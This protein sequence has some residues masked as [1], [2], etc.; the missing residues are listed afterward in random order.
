MTYR[1]QAV[2]LRTDNSSEGMARIAAVWQDIVSGKLP[3]LADS[4]GVMHSGLSPISRYSNY[5]EEERGLYDLTIMTVSPEFFER[6]E[7]KVQAGLYKKYETADASGDVGVCTKAAWKAVWADQQ[8]G[9]CRRAFTEDY[10]S[11]V[12]PVFTKDGTAH[13]S[14]YIALR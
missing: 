14:L 2:T 11:T 13:C 5:A 8:N 7:E 6:M 10:E 4:D 12:P 1:L 3:L 9:T